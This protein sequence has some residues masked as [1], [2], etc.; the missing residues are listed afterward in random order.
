L[1]NLKEQTVYLWANNGT[2]PCI[3]IGRAVRFRR[4][5]IF[6]MLDL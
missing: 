6:E 1:L 3:K 5:E 4:D 2:L